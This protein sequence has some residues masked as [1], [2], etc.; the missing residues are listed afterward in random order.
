[1]RARPKARASRPARPAKPVKPVKPV[2]G[3]VA[4]VMNGVRALV[5]ALS[6]SARAVERDTGVTNAQLFVLRELADNEPLSI[7][8][9]AARAMTLHSTASLLVTR[10]VNLGL[11]R[12]EADANDARRAL[13]TLTARG[14]RIVDQAPEPPTALVLR[15]LRK[16]TPQTRG[17]LDDALTQLL[18]SMG[19]SREESPPLFERS[20][21]RVRRREPR[22]SAS[23]R[24]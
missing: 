9:I 15:A 17:Q 12:R 5:A 24:R 1:M 23:P 14:R 13:I 20:P 10:L 22:S 18:D 19:L 3:S 21:A 2:N 6:Q 8:D 16:L 7:N 4:D 11:V